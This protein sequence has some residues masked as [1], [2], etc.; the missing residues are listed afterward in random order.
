MGEWCPSIVQLLKREENKND[1]GQLFPLP[2]GKRR[3][4]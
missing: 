3:E 4:F 2:V 1:G